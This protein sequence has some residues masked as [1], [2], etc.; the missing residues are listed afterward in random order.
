MVN[1]SNGRLVKPQS[2]FKATATNHLSYKGVADYARSRNFYMDLLGMKC[3]YDDGER[4]S[5]SFGDPERSI[6]IWSGESKPYVDHFAFSIADFGLEGV[7]AELEKWGF[8]PE[9]DGDYAWTIWD[10]DGYKVQICAERGVFPG[11]ARPG[12]TTEGKIP[13]GEAGQHPGVFQATAVN[14][15]AYRVPDHA[16][17]RNFYMDLF[18]MRLAFEDGKK[19]SVAF[20]QPEDAIYI[21]ATKSPNDGATVDHL[22]F[23]IANFDLKAVGEKLRNQ[24]HE[25]EDDGDYARTIWDPDGY[26]IQICAEAGVYPG[27]RQDPHHN[28]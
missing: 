15:I 28:R 20:G 7:K 4:C 6:Y 5:V 27:A 22:A 11:A 2:I 17:S 9:D 3:T 8:E 19:C 10:P 16:R 13:T 23:S 18:G 25:S 12:A 1:N 14:H 21:V 26:K 24:G